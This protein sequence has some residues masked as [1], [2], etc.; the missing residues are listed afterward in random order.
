M[1][2]KY[3]Y[4]LGILF[5]GVVSFLIQSVPIAGAA[6][7]SENTYSKSDYTGA[8]NPEDYKKLCQKFPF[9]VFECG[10]SYCNPFVENA[11]PFE[12]ASSSNSDLNDYNYSRFLEKGVGLEE[13][14]SCIDMAL[15]SDSSKGYTINEMADKL[16]YGAIKVLE[17][18]DNKI[19]YIP[20]ETSG[21]QEISASDGY[22]AT[23]GFNIRQTMNWAVFKKHSLGAEVS[24][25]RVYEEAFNE[26]T[27]GYIAFIAL[28]ILFFMI[29]ANSSQSGG[30]SPDFGPAAA[31]IIKQPWATLPLSSLIL[32]LTKKPDPFRNYDQRS[33]YHADLSG[34]LN[35][36]R[37][38][39]GD[40]NFTSAVNI[41]FARSGALNFR[42]DARYPRTISLLPVNG[43]VQ[44]KIYSIIEIILIPPE[45]DEKPL[46]RSSDFILRDEL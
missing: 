5:P 45:G 43:A 26:K 33:L 6:P 11:A 25:W 19:W 20:F 32:K 12:P 9:Q 42:M 36:P 34:P 27:S 21:L 39:Q 18:K 37:D 22:E 46:Y 7:Y 1:K 14:E 8:K 23:Y 24:E 3:W 17:I 30:R 29:V 31:A 13:E 4:R 28:T 44:T 15:L 41:R 38:M 10:R 40:I 16:L 35:L 2:K